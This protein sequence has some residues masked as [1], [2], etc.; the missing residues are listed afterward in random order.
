MR[1]NDSCKRDHAYCCFSNREKIKLICQQLVTP[2]IEFHQI[3]LGKAYR[4]SV[5]S[6]IKPNQRYIAISDK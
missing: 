2:K 6:P 3:L 5:V 4:N 1:P